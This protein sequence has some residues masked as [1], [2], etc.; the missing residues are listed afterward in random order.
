MDDRKEIL[1]TYRH[2]LFLSWIAFSIFIL[3]TSGFN[4]DHRSLFLAVYVVFAMVFSIFLSAWPEPDLDKKIFK[5]E[6]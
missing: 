2:L 4:F 3:W 6:S 1:M 5:N